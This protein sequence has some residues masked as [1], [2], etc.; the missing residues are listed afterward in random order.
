M[1]RLIPISILRLLSIADSISSP[2]STFE[3]T[4]T[5]LYTQ[6][7]MTL[8]LI[9]ATALCLHN[10]LRF[11]NSGIMDMTVGTGGVVSTLYGPGK[12]S[13]GRSRQC[14]TDKSN[15]PKAFESV[16]L[17]SLGRSQNNNA[18]AFHADSISMA[19]DSSRRNIMVR[20]TVDVQYEAPDGAIDGRAVGPG[21]TR[22]L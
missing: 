16:K 4:T 15:N 20:H 19:S 2:N 3:Y 8:A 12:S 22:Q 21:N 10:F 5:E 14:G 18:N 7:E 9:N 1:T 11:A 13:T 17:S 6:I